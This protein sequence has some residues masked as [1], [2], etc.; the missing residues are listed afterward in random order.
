MCYA[1]YLQESERKEALERAQWRKA[2]ELGVEK[3]FLE[4]QTFPGD[5]MFQAI[6]QAIKGEHPA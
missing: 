6:L 4:D 3:S 1:G 2:K 5:R